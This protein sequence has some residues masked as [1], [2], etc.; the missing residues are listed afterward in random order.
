[1]KLFFTLLFCAL[2]SSCGGGISSNSDNDPPPP[3]PTEDCDILE[4]EPNDDFFNAQ[5]ID[6]LPSI[7]T[8]P[9]VCG[10][11]FPVGG[12]IDNYYFPLAPN[13]GVT[14]LLLTL[15]I[16]TDF[17][18]VPVVELLQTIYDPLGAPTGTYQSLGTF[19]GAEGVLILLD[20]P[21]PYDLLN[22]NDLF[23][24]V[25]GLPAPPSPFEKLY[26]LEY[27]TR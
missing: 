10:N 3:D 26:Q 14:N 18:V 13:P 27:F 22:Q 24:R 5:F 23:I 20:W 9:I 11:F 8:N 4:L 2:L 17:D 1:M 19:F 21:V 6:V 16:D 12:D 15:I 7:P 25:T